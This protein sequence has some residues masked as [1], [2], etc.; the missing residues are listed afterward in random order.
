MTITLSFTNFLLLILTVAFL[1]IGGY[2][3][4]ILRKFSK[5][6]EN[7]DSLLPYIKE[8][9]IKSKD[10]LSKAESLLEESEETVRE[11]KFA[12]TRVRG[13]IEE[14]ANVVEDVLSVIKPISIIAQSFKAGFS[15]FQ[16]LFK[17]VENK[18]E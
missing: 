3:L 14:T 2:L 11:A 9:T 7:V 6:I 13:V 15:L 1:I 10:V 8:I 18:E 5:F 17:K 16:N 4:A 12:T